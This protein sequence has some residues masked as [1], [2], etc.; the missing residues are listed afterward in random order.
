MNVRSIKP[1]TAPFSE[2]VTS[3]KLDIV[4]VTET[5]LKHDETKSTIADISPPGYSFFHK[6]RADQ[7]AGGGV[8]IL[9][10]DKFKTDIHP[11]QSFKTFEAISAR[12]GNNSFSGFVV[13]LYRLKNG[14]CQF[15]DEFQDLLQN[16][17]SLYDNLYVLGDFNLHLDN[18]RYGNTNKFNEILTCFDLKQHVNFPAHVHGH[19][20]DLLI[21]KR[22]SNC[23]KSVFSAAGISD[24]LAVISE[25]DCCK[26]KWNKEKILFRK[27]NKIDYESFHSDILSSDL[28]KKPE[29]DLSALCQQYDSALSSILDKHAP[30]GTQILPRKPPTPWMTP[31]I[32]KAKTLSHNLEQ[33]WCRSRTHLD[34]SRYKLC[35]RMMTKSKSKYSAD[36]IAENSDKP[37]R[38]WYSI[39]NILHKIPPPA[40]PEF[41]SVK[42]LCDHFSRYFVDKIET[43]RSKFPDKGQNIPQVQK[44]EIRS[45]MNVFER[46]SKSC[47]LDPIPTSV[48]KNCLDILITPITDIPFQWKLVHFLKI[49]KKL[50]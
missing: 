39:N 41:I 37:R 38:L 42:S 12:I 18:S 7:R 14:T 32:I 8:G 33:T 1:K 23:I 22:I 15:F 24:H 21:T 49:S 3:N 50:M 4:A 19:W 34:H 29:I 36:V 17:I 2:Y 6:P 35:N 5:W 40:L 25:I 10:S 16:I 28:I 13:C 9:V 46:A 31:E 26:T 30:V 27:I 43:I 44:T 45:K 48:L 47:D 20:L 11:L